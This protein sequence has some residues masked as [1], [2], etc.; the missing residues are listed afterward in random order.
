MNKFLLLL[1]ILGSNRSK[2]LTYNL[3][4]FGT[5]TDRL[6]RKQ[7]VRESDTKLHHLCTGLK[8]DPVSKRNKHKSRDDLFEYHR[9][10]FLSK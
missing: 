4:A 1:Q 8:S 3:T 10:V 2:A 7:K 5:D 6:T 9:A